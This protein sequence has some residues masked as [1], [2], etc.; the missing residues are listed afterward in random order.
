MTYYVLLTLLSAFRAW[1]MR[2]QL[3]V[4]GMFDDR[5]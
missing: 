1:A 4:E 3:E 2:T 5:G